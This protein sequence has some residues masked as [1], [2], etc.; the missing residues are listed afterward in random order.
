MG[1]AE[2]PDNRQIS[3]WYNDIWRCW[4]AC[5][6][7]YDLDVHVESGETEAEAIENLKEGDTP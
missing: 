5:F 6:G 2:Q 3:T 7:E 1:D 4:Y